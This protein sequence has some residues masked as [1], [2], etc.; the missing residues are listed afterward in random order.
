MLWMNPVAESLLPSS[1]WLGCS[2][3]QHGLSG[4]GVYKAHLP[5]TLFQLGVIW[6]S[7]PGEAGSSLWPH[8]L[9]FRS[10]RTLELR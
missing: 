9:S 6:T 2:L 5:W 7:S 4:Q 1:S 3:L 10:D 8:G